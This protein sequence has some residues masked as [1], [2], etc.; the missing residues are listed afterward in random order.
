MDNYK[1]LV[2][3]FTEIK[4]RGFIKT[5]RKG[6]TGV[7]ATFEWLIGKQ[8][9]I[10]PIPD[11]Y[12]IEIKT[13][14]KNSTSHINLFN[15]TPDSNII[16][17]VERIV[18]LYGYPDSTVKNMKILNNDAYGSHYNLV[19]LRY[20]FKLFVDYTKKRV[21]LCVYNY[22]FRLIDNKTYWT[23]ALLKEKLERKMQYLA[24]IIAD[25]IFLEGAEYFHYKRLEFMKLKSFEIFL[26]LIEYGIIR[27]TFKVGVHKDLKYFGKRYHHGVTFNIRYEDMNLL[28]KILEIIE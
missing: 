28:Y 12:E 13:K 5:I 27:V 8:E 2:S 1:L 21:Y 23:F 19:S 16:L 10:F 26:S 3:K 9:D 24:I 4:D 7:G 14:R 6:S 22:Y 20:R 11:F 17:G 25:N 15:A 18:N